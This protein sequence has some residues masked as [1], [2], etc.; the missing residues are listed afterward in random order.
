MA[1][2]LIH[3]FAGGTLNRAALERPLEGF[4]DAQL[5]SATAQIISFAGDRALIDVSDDQP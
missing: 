1:D 2:E 3:S 5:T 4:V